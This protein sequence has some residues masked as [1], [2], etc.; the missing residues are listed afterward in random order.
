MKIYVDKISPNPEQPR[1]SFDQK[2]IEELASSIKSQGLLAPILVEDLGDGQY[3]L[4]HGE[5]R[6]RA[7][8]FLGLKEIEAT[9]RPVSN[10]NG[11]DRLIDA[12]AENVARKNMN[13]VDEAFAYQRMIEKG[14]SVTE[15]ARRVGISVP[16]IYSK[17]KILKFSEAEQELMA[18]KKLPVVDGALDALLAIPSEEERI[19]MS[20][21]LAEKGANGSVVIRACEKFLTMKRAVRKQKKSN[22][23]STPAISQI[24]Q[25]ELPEWDALYQVGKVPPWKVF[26]ESVMAT[27]DSCSLRAN[28]S[29]ATCG[30]CPLVVMVEK[31][32]EKVRHG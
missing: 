21:R 9:V 19:N 16:K 23:G 4:V 7:C 15:I 22:K 10:H 29:D 3:Q 18:A 27:C 20:M 2:E 8:K 31:T 28:A 26:T 17:L 1:R 11:L 12:T 24:S 14:K 5:R 25:K 30:Y 13:P 32:L 6:L